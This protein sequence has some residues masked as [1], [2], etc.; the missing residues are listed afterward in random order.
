MSV[1]VRL[2][3]IVCLR[4]WVT[5]TVIESECVGDCESECLKIW[6]FLFTS[7]LVRF[8][9]SIEVDIVGVANPCHCTC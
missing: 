5:V 9:L 2:R 3:V 8:F 1:C 7:Q 6:L 4:V